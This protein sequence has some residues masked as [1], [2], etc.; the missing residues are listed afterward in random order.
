MKEL[1]RTLQ[2]QPDLAN[3]QPGLTLAGLNYP[4]SG[5]AG[6]CLKLGS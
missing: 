4:Q 3:I 2:Q 5:L 1:N 6:S